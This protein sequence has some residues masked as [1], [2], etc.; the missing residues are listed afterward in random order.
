MTATILDKRFF[1]LT[2][3]AGNWTANNPVLGKGEFGIEVEADGTVGGTKA[4]NGIDAWNDLGYVIGGG[5][6]SGAIDGG[7]PGS[8]FGG[9]SGIDGG[10][11]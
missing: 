2:D 5:A 6:G 11:P 4:G 3:T 8:D 10:S 1:N 7:S 9:T